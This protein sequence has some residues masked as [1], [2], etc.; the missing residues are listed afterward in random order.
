M[1]VVLTPVSTILHGLLGMF[2]KARR[3]WLYSDIYH[4]KL[5]I[6]RFCFIT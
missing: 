1:V 5:C 3:E 6:S 4:F 2:G